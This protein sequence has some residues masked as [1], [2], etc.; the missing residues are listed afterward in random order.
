[1]ASL[2]RSLIQLYLFVLLIRV[3]LSWFPISPGSAMA[4]VYRFCHTITEP[5]LA[6]VRRLIPQV[7]MFDLSPLIVFIVGELLVS[8]L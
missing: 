5:V 7:G 1:V 8:R 6:P 2:I 3:V 4:S